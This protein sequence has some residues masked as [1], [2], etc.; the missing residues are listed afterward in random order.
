MHMGSLRSSFLGSTI[1]TLIVAAV[2]MEKN[3]LRFIPEFT[4]PRAWGDLLGMADR[5]W[6]GW[7]VYLV[8]GIAI[9]GI[10]F[11]LMYSIQAR[12]VQPG[13]QPDI[14]HAAGVDLQVGRSARRR[15]LS[16]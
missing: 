9:C 7:V 11:A 8:V 10:A 14:R 4:M 5:P 1:A 2:T 13:T 6:V 3:A 12:A 15:G 16:D